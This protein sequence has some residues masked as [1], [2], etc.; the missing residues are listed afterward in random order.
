MKTPQPG[1]VVT[2]K[3]DLEGFS[4]KNQ[5]LVVKSGFD[6]ILLVNDYGYKVWRYHGYFHNITQYPIW[7]RICNFVNKILGI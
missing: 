1:D 7:E 3:E 6:L 5:Y 4:T 2:P